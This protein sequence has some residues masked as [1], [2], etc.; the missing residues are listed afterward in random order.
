MSAQS[1]LLPLEQLL[2][3]EGHEDPIKY[4]VVAAVIYMLELDAKFLQ[5]KTLYA[6]VAGR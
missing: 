6:L 1:R 2:A 5:L 4:V 3:R